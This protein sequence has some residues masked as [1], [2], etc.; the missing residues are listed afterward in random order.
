MSRRSLLKPSENA[1]LC[2]HCPRRPKDLE[3]LDSRSVGDQP[4]SISGFPWALP[5]P[6]L[7]SGPLGSL[8]QTSSGSLSRMPS[9]DEV[10]ASMQA[11]MQR[12]LSAERQRMGRISLTQSMESMQQ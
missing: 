4:F 5:S 1:G 3:R 6:Y 11:S 12:E 2:C 8:T 10:F 9:H 7:L